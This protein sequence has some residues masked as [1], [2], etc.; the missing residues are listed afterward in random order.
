MKGLPIEFPSRPPEAT[1][2]T[3]AGA[4]R[5]HAVSFAG[6]GTAMWQARNRFCRETAR[7]AP[8]VRQHSPDPNSAW[9]VGARVRLDVG[10]VVGELDE[11]VDGLHVVWVRLGGELREVHQVRKHRLYTR[12]TARPRRHRPDSC[13][14]GPG[15]RREG[16][17]W[18]TVQRKAR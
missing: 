7:G 12:S 1:D 14:S 6:Q 10:P 18:L 15:P 2:L 3:A 17:F 4:H 9:V 13:Q 11:E 8:G 16:S 5:A